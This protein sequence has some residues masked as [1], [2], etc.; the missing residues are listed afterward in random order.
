M[1]KKYFV[2]PENIPSANDGDEHYISSSALMALYGVPRNECLV[3][4]VRLPARQRQK[5]EEELIVLRPLFN[6]KYQ[7]YINAKQ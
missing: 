7:E 5:Y 6:G 3:D 2:I 4:S 1:T